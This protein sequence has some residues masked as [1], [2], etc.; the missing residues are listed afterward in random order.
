MARNHRTKSEVYYYDFGSA[1][2]LKDA[3]KLNF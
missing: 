2:A 1:N 3:K